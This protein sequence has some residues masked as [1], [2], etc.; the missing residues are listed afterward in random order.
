MVEKGGRETERRQETGKEK[1]E[2][3]Q[4]FF[5]P[6][7]QVLAPPEGHMLSQPLIVQLRVV[8]LFLSFFGWFK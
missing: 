5:L 2:G 7:L 6:F 4:E 3:Q 8:S 1:Q